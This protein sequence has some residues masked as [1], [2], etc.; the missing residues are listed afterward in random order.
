VPFIT[1]NEP[2][3]FDPLEFCFQFLEI[4][5]I[6]K[7]QMQKIQ[8]FQREKDDI[9]CIMYMKLAQF[10]KENDDACME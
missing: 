2:L 3:P 8:D 7:Y 6:H 5:G 10:T 1:I 4:G 9:P